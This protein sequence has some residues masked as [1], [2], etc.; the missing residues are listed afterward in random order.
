MHFLNFNFLNKNHFIVKNKQITLCRYINVSTKTTSYTDSKSMHFNELFYTVRI[1][2]LI[3]LAFTLDFSIFLSITF[4]LTYPPQKP[5]IYHRVKMN[6]SISFIL[7]FVIHF[8]F[9]HIPFF[10]SANTILFLV[11]FLHEI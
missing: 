1:S 11:S 8:S 2:I 5:T 10:R 6:K 4:L 9:S 3:L 7:S